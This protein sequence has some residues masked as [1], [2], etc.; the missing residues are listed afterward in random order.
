MDLLV[1]ELLSHV[2]EQE[3]DFP[4]VPAEGACKDGHADA[5]EA[6]GNGVVH[7]HACETVARQSA[8]AQADG[9]GR[10]VKQTHLP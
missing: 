10:Q 4:G 1:L 8:H 5:R 2:D 3:L 7:P 9:T 6:A